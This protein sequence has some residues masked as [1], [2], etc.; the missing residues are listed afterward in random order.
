[1][2]QFWFGFANN[3]SSATIYDPW[4]YQLYNVL[5]TSFP[6]IVYAIYDQQNSVK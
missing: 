2:P 1:M 5:F 6:I 4:V 3:F